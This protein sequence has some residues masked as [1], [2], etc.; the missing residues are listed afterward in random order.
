M[1]LYGS[2][3]EEQLVL[4]RKRHAHFTEIVKGYTSFDDFMRDWDEEMAL[5]GVEATKGEN[6]ISLYIPM[7]DTEY[8]EY[9]VIMDKDGHL[10]IS[11]EVWW[12]EL[13]ANTL[14]DIFTGK[15]V[16]R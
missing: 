5:W 7:D 9:M 14:T 2:T 12:N 4:M 1:K 13:F 11:A 16:Y 10:E 6:R 15:N 3:R 8:E